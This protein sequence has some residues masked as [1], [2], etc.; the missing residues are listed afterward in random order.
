MAYVIF[1]KETP[2]NEENSFAKIAANDTERDK[3]HPTSFSDF[4]KIYNISDDDFNAL[5]LNTK[6]CSHDGTNVT[7]SSVNKT[8]FNSATISTP[9][10]TEIEARIKKYTEEIR[11]Y[12]EKNTQVAD[13]NKSDWLSYADTVDG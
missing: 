12:F 6:T 1:N 2:L 11:E 13:A 7:F 4:Y 5:R 9:T 10:Q 8:A 3:V